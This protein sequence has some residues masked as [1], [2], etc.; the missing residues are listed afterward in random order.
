MQREPHV[1]VVGGGVSGLTAAYRLTRSG[2]R[3][4]VLESAPRTGGKLDASDVAGVPVDS[5]A[6]SVLARRPEAL[7]LIRELGL[8]DRLV[9]PARVPAAI[10]SRGR[11]RA[12]P[13]GHV[14]GVPGGLRALARSGVVSPAGTLRAALDLVRP[15]TPV[16]GDVPVGAYVGAR[17]GREVVDRLVEPMLGGV[18]A[19]RADRLSLDSTLPQ[20]AAVA[21]ADRSL[22][23]AVRAITARAAGTPGGPVFATLDGGLATLADA[24]V[25]RS[26]AAV[27]TSTTVRGLAPEG[28]GWRLTTGS[29]A[30]GRTGRTHDAD[31]VVLACPA[32]A[33]GRLLRPFAPAAAEE[34]AGIAY[35][36]MAIVTLAYP[37]S[38]FARPPAG[39]GFLVPAREGRAIKAATFSS[40]KWPW[41]A[42]R[43]AARPGP[44][45]VVIR[46]SIG[47]VGEE[48]VLQRPDDDLA[49]LAVADLADICGISG[50]P[51]DIRVTRWGGGLPQ[52]DAGHAARVGRAR[53][54]LAGHPALALCGA[55]YDGV[56]IPACI[57]GATG[58]AERIA[59]ALPV[60]AAGAA[61]TGTHHARRSEQAPSDTQGESA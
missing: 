60:P 1:V 55:A 31:A 29:A 45:T 49:A 21:G 39:S 56:G 34:L 38:A 13:A 57:A 36:S 17:L 44:E 32:P 19:G 23:R 46:C 37:A 3:V 6:E 4:T 18:Y 28:A 2:A 15:R 24:L 47:R 8:G 51:A 7:D 41:L 40:V 33:A 20:I 59:A 61:R 14:M 12:F 22:I 35:A 53:A 50:P 48:A 9:H 25:E 16:R 10:Y 43:L 5:G 26:G 11:L 58:A 30:G 54:A 27:A 52:Y 42:E